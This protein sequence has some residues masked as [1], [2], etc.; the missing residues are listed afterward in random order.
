MSTTI[1][2]KTKMVERPRFSWGWVLVLFLLVTSNSLMAQAGGAN[3]NAFNF[4]IG[5]NLP[6]E[7]QRIDVAIRIL[8]LIT[9]LAVAPSLVMLMT[10]FTRIIIVFSFLRSLGISESAATVDADGIEHHVSSETLKAFQ[11]FISQSESD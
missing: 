5:M 11:R 6:E 7:P 4:N 2:N 8:F 9:L 3:T 10:C 1:Q